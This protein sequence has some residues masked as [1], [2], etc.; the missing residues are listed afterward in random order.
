MP[1]SIPA[2][3]LAHCLV[4]LTVLVSLGVPFTALAGPTTTAPSTTPS[5]APAPTS[6]GTAGDAAAKHAKRTACLKQAKAKKL[7]GADKK[8][9]VKEC[10]A[11][12]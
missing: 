1:S 12:P 4:S 10:L 8:A 7:V 6:D 2:S 9:F 5:P 3:V 11:A